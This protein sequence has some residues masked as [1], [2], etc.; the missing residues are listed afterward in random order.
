MK[1]YV[2]SLFLC[3]YKALSQLPPQ[4]SPGPGVLPM[5]LPSPPGM[6]CTTTP[7]QGP[8]PWL[9][10]LLPKIQKTKPTVTEGQTSAGPIPYFIG[11]ETRN[12]RNK[13]TCPDSHNDI[14]TSPEDNTEVISTRS[15]ADLHSYQQGLFVRPQVKM[16]KGVLHCPRALALD[17]PSTVMT[18]TM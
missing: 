4:C 10:C 14:W 16:E 17:Q 5:A 1:Y 6:K 8:H 3:S 9:W 15:F 7:S 18:R 2:S 11:R 13:D 12:W